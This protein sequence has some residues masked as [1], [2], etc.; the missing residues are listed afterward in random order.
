MDGIKVGDSMLS[1]NEILREWRSQ[2]DGLDI[3][4]TLATLENYPIS[5]KFDQPKLLANEKI[6]LASMFYSL[7]AIRCQLSPEKR[8]LLCACVSNGRYLIL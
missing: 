4:D 2:K 8:I 6:R 3:L 5:V 7:F 1:I